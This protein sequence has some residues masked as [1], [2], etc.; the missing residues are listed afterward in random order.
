MLPTHAWIKII[1]ITGALI[2]GFS[3]Y[4][5]SKKPDSMLEQASEAVLRTQGV[6]IDFSP[7]D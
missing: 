1:L 7:E 4:L 5:L 6:D 3:S 2:V